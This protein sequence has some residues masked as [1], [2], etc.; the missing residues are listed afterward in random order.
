MEIFEMVFALFLLGSIGVAA[1]TTIETANTSGWGDTTI[2]V[3]G[4]VGVM[5]I[6]GVVYK[7]LPK[8]GG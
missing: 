5:A 3:W 7:F 4:L 8:G 6:L 2:V 1:V